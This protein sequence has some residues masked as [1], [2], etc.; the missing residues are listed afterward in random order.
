LDEARDTPE[1]LRDVHLIAYRAM[2]E[3]GQRATALEHLRA[4]EAAMR[5][6]AETL[7]P[8]DRLRFLERVPYN[9]R[10]VEAVADNSEFT[11]ARL[12]RAAAPL[13]RALAEADFVAVR[14]TLSTVS[15]AAISDAT[16]RRRHILRRLLAEAGAQ[17]A[18]PTDADLARALGVAR[19][20]IE[21]DMAALQA[22]G[23]A[24]PTRR[25]KS[26]A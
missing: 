8:E 7:A 4:A 21:R 5:A 10:V 25:R 17:S 2:A 11:T 26:P 6:L 24:L 15:D 20:T 1:I 3:W 14:W 9:R 23:H 18:A 19:R 16:E 13:G 22:A 12:A